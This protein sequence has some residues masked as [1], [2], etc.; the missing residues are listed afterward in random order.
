[1]RSLIAK[2]ENNVHESG[3]QLRQADPTSPVTNQLWINTTTKK[4]SYFDTMVTNLMDGYTEGNAPSELVELTFTEVDW[5]LGSF[6]RRKNISGTTNFT[7]INPVEG[8]SIILLVIAGS[9]TPATVVLPSYV[10]KVA[11]DDYSL[12]RGMGIAIEL[13]QI[14]GVTYA[15]IIYRSFIADF[16]SGALGDLVINSGQTVNIPAGSI[17]DYRNVTINAGGTLNI[18]GGASPVV[19]IITTLS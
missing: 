10:K 19:T 11:T 16:P 3:A 6:F 14:S 17:L 5:T 13:T 2:K 7:F 4:L 8:K 1:M 18:Q 9:L 12:T 15:K